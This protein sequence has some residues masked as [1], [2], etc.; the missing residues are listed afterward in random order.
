MTSKSNL[1]NCVTHAVAQHISIIGDIS[2]TIAKVTESPKLRRQF[3][4]ISQSAILSKSEEG[5]CVVESVF[6]V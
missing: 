2:D 5:V 1:E 6:E 4:A 3:S